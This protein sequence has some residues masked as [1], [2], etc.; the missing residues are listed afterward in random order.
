MSPCSDENGIYARAANC[1]F[2]PSH[3]RAMWLAR[4]SALKKTH[5]CILCNEQSVRYQR[6]IAFGAMI[7]LFLIAKRKARDIEPRNYRTARYS[8][9]RRGFNVLA[10]CEGRGNARENTRDKLA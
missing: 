3:L 9:A 2:M 10:R 1:K 8:V 7:P 6:A 4:A 5:F